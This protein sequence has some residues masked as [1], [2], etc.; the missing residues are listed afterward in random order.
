[1]VIASRTLKLT[2]PTGETDVPIRVFRPEQIGGDWTCRFEIDWPDEQEAMEMR[3]Y[4][5][6]QVLVLALQMVG[7]RIHASDEHQSGRLFLEAPGR[8]Y[9]F[10]V[11]PSERGLL[12][13][14]D[15]K[16]L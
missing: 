15:A 7:S 8:G 2:V 6:V 13:G 11:L 12:V 9:G 1:M 10:P 16:Y 3:G 4:D 5:S 14:D